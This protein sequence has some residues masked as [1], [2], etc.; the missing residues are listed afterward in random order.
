MKHSFIRKL[1]I[2][3]ALCIASPINAKSFDIKQLECK[4]EFCD[5]VAKKVVYKP[6][7]LVASINLVT[8]HFSID[9][10]DK[11]IRRIVAS[12]GDV[13]V[14]YKDNNVLIIS[15][16]SAP[17]IDNLSKD[18]AYKLPD[19]V[20]TKTLSTGETNDLPK[21][22]FKKVAILQKQ[23]YFSKASEV[24]YSENGETKYFISN[25]NEMGFSGSAMVSTPKTKEVFLKIDAEKMDF[26]VFKKV[27]LS[28]N[29]IKGN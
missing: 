10:P 26:E 22:T 14:Y 15:E 18:L 3:L 2:L 6:D 25:S 11:P 24:T 13:I 20:F 5:A 1:Y 27:V 19:M 8:D 12:D 4:N 16:Q 21:K 17:D 9:I 29:S 23:F 7:K 28:V